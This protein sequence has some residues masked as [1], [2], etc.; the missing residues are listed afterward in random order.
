MRWEGSAEAWK[1]IC[2]LIL[3]HSWLNR[4]V[5][6]VVSVLE[7]EY[8]CSSWMAMIPKIERGRPFWNAT[9][10]KLSKEVGA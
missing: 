4:Y 10:G 6:L 2:I 9:A 7:R 5:R 1:S 3:R 8:V